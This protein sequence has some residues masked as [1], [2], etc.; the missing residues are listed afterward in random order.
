MHLAVRN[1]THR[2]ENAP[3][4]KAHQNLRMRPM[5]SKRRAYYDALAV[6]T[7]E[8]HTRAT[9]L[10]NDPAY[11]LPNELRQPA[12]QAEAQDPLEHHARGATPVARATNADKLG[13][14]LQHRG[15]EFPTAQDAQSAKHADPMT[16]KN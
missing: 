5:I 6:L 8:Q 12:P 13:T 1:E 16:H 3:G 4:L 15:G 2:Y 14:P 10:F 7:P 9:A 11:E